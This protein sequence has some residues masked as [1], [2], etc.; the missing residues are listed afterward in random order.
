MSKPT[1]VLVPGACARPEFYDTVVEPVRAKG[2]EMKGLHLPCVAPSPEPYDHDPPNMYDD[3]AF[4][5]KEVEKLAD[6]GKDVVL[7]T[8]SYGGAPATQST[9]GLTKAERQK[10][11]KPGGI[12]RLAYMTSLVPALGQTA[13]AVLPSDPN[14]RVSLV[15]DERGWLYHSDPAASARLSLSDLSEEDGV[16]WINKFS[17]QSSLCFVDPLTHAGY[18]DLPVSYLVCER[19]QCIP[20]QT[21]KEEIE[22]IEKVSGRKVGVTSIPNDHC[23]MML[24]PEKVTDW[25]LSLV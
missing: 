19:D 23:P 21:Q 17:R 2:Y 25:F 5:A 16:A 8:H 10:E 18:A 6:E 3:A 13:G 4:I 7:V 14:A 24:A 22:M 11:G 20:L 15:P 9:K 12:V 1:L